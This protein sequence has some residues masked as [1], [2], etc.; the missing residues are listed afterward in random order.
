M[1]FQKLTVQFVAVGHFGLPVASLAFDVESQT[2]RASDSG[3]SDGSSDASSV[4][5]DYITAIAVGRQAEI[6]LRWPGFTQ[7]FG[8]LGWFFG[9]VLTEDSG[10]IDGRYA[11]KSRNNAIIELIWE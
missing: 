2:G 5:T 10:R 8:R 6:L 3:Q 4:T 1:F 11:C 9:A 7:L